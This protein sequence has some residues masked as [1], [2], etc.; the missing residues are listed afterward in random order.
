MKSNTLYLVLVLWAILSMAC[1]GGG[2]PA[3]ETICDDG[4]DG[5]GDGMPDCFDADCSCVNTGGPIPDDVCMCLLE[6]AEPVCFLDHEAETC[7]Y[8]D[9][10]QEGDF[11]FGGRYPVLNIGTCIAGCERFGYL[12]TVE[13]GVVIDDSSYTISATELDDAVVYASDWLFRKTGAVMK[14][15][16]TRHVPSV[17]GSMQGEIDAYYSAHATDPP[18][19]VMVASADDS[20]LSFGGYAILSSDLSGSGFCN[21][22]VSPVHGSS[23]IY[24]AVIDWTHR[25]SACGYDLDHYENTGEY[26]QVST[27]SLADGT[28]R[29]QAEVACVYNSVVDYQV[30]STSD[31]SLP[32]LQHPRAMI[33]STFIHEVLHS[34]G[35][36]GNMDHFGTTTCDTSMGGEDYGA[37]DSFSFQEWAGM[38]PNTWQNFAQSY[39]SCP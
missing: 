14:L 38:C 4:I 24:G 21:E 29:N 7:R 17:S 13:T 8:T 28:C 39:V 12:K 6:E 31:P 37:G 26:I 1:N 18:N 15:Q 19:F 36:N 5:D 25:F 20:S 22:F 27:T 11:G 35:T 30:C 34:F 10:Y 3:S 9:S 32:Y 16:A 2:P 33:F 23:R